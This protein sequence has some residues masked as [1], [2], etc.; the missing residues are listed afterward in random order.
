LEGSEAVIFAAAAST[1]DRI[2]PEVHDPFRARG[3]EVVRSFG[4]GDE[5]EL[6]TLPTEFRAIDRAAAI[7]A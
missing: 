3:I 7:R 2:A 4:T 5:D 6:L 1:S